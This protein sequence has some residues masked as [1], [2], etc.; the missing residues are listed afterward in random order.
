MPRV[1]GSFQSSISSSE[2]S[3][4]ALFCGRQPNRAIR[5]RAIQSRGRNSGT[6][7][8][9]RSWKVSKPEKRHYSCSPR[10]MVSFSILSTQ[11]S[12]DTDLGE[13]VKWTQ[14]GQ[15]CNT[16]LDGAQGCAFWDWT[17]W[18]QDRAAQGI[19]RKYEHKELR[20]ILREEDL[21]W[22]LV[23]ILLISDLG[24]ALECL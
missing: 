12:H 19:Q 18:N 10:H 3:M 5:N 15:L 6:S 2:G 14:G 13:N 16:A 20:E 24:K 7:K 9:E 8:V 22:N 23:W 4:G 21:D 11:S 17:T 1:L